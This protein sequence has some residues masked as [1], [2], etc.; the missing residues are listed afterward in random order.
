MKRIVVPTR[1]FEDWKRLLAQPDL[2]WKVGYSAMTLARSWEAADPS[3]PPEVQ[4]ALESTRDPVLHD[5]DLLL[6]IPEYKV[7]L[8]GGQ[9]P[10]QTDV[11]ALMR[12]GAGLVAVAVEGKV[13]E[14]FGPSVGAQLKGATI[15]ANRRFEWLS[16]QLGLAS[17][18]DT[19]RYQ[20]LHRTVSALLVAEQFNAAAAV[21]LVQ[22]FSP[23]GKRF[24]DFKAFAELLGVKAEVGRVVRVRRDTRIP[25]Y[26]GWCTGDRRFRAER[27]RI[28]DDRFTWKPGD[29]EIIRPP[30]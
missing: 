26:V 3:A 13:D 25:L 22:S 30:K 29:V 11:L 20:L 1:S 19:I 4:A 6:A 14:P 23:T 18:P 27:T 21:M 7:A 12:G 24:G 16:D 15:G 2:H 9:R 5:L 8:P 17:V 10:S 28:A